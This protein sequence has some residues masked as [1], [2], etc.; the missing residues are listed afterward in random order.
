MLRLLLVSLFLIL[1]FLASMLI[2]DAAMP[3][4]PMTDACRDHMLDF[5][6]DDANNR[7]I[8]NILHQ[9]GSFCPDQLTD[10]LTLP[11]DISK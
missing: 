8:F 5:Y 6:A 3:P 9:W 11:P 7:H 4:T 10:S 2:H 1:L